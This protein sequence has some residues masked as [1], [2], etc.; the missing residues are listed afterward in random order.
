MN[1]IFYFQVK[2]DLTAIAMIGIS[3]VVLFRGNS[4]SELSL[5]FI[6]FSTKLLQFLV[7]D[8]IKSLIL[9]HSFSLLLLLSLLLLFCFHW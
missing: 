2:L 1:K 6:F 3:I 9:L 7:I 5:I 4:S 8:L